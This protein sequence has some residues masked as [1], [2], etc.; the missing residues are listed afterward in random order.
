MVMF[1]DLLWDFEGTIKNSLGESTPPK[2]EPWT[3]VQGMNL[4]GFEARSSIP[5]FVFSTGVRHATLRKSQYPCGTTSK[6]SPVIVRYCG[7]HPGQQP[8]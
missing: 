2:A 3:C 1:L 7:S 8:W 6:I 4:N 5:V